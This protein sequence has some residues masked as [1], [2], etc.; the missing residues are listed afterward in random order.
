MSDELELETCF[1][2]GGVGMHYD[3]CKWPTRPFS[4]SYNPE[5]DALGPPPTLLC[6]RCSDRPLSEFRRAFEEVAPNDP[7]K[8]TVEV[9]VHRPCKRLVYLEVVM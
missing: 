5:A 9:W 1:H 6:P 8:P 4:E 7:V 2:C 3:D